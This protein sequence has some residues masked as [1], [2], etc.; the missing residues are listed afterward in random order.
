MP[1]YSG[2]ESLA[3]AIYIR[4]E[5]LKKQNV[6]IAT[7][8]SLETPRSYV[9]CVYVPD[10]FLKFLG[11]SKKD[12]FKFRVYSF[13]PYGYNITS[14]T[15]MLC[16]SSESKPFKDQDEA[17]NAAYKYLDEIDN[18]KPWRDPKLDIEWIKSE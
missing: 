13:D 11:L 2:I 15:K 6:R 16:L 3:S 5:D 4:E 17:V 14:V 18:R 12:K 9:A 10:S 8:R 1:K 7:D